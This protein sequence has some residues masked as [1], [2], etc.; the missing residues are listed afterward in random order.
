MGLG[1]ARAFTQKCGL[2]CPGGLTPSWF[3]PLSFVV[4]TLLTRQLTDHFLPHSPGS[5]GPSGPV[6]GFGILSRCSLGPAG[7]GQLDTSPGG[8][9]SYSIQQTQGS[10]VLSFLPLHETW[11]RPGAFSAG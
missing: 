11:G 3:R 7:R 4:M 6:L 9:S 10:Y 1:V 5:A 8:H 2:C